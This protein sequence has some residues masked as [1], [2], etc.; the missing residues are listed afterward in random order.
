MTLSSIQ[1]LLSD[2]DGTIYLGDRLIPGAREAVQTVRN[3][4]IPVVFLTNKAIERRADYCKKLNDLGIPTTPSDIVTSATMTANFLAVNHPTQSVYVV[5]EK[6]LREELEA[7]NV[8]LATTPEEAGILLASMDRQFDYERLTKAMNALDDTTAFIATNPDRTCPTGDG[9]IPDCAAMVGA[10][11]GASGRNV[12]QIIGKPSQ[13]AID[14]ATA[15]IGVDPEGC[16]IVGDRLET[17]IEMGNRAGMTTILVLSG[18]TDENTVNQSR[19]QPDYV[20][21]SIAELG[22]LL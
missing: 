10:I 16:A 14:A 17:D 7:R 20:I 21:D 9:E 13:T 2:L 11:E 8:E 15:T 3:R 19:I 18:V 5:G 1:G 6:P 22:T 12:Q 4:D